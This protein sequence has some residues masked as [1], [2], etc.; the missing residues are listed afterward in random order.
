MTRPT[1]GAGQGTSYST[2]TEDSETA[3]TEEEKAQ[4]RFGVAE[5]EFHAQKRLAAQRAREEKD[6]QHRDAMGK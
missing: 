3:F 2:L 4:I 5:R 6:K 1:A